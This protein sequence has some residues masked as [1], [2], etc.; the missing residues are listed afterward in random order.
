MIDLGT[1]H[2]PSSLEAVMLSLDEMQWLLESLEDV[3]L[4]VVLD[5]LGRYDNRDDHDAA[6]RAARASLDAR[7]LLESDSASRDLEDRLRVL[8]RPHWVLALR[9]FTGEHIS[10]LCVAQ[11]ADMAV[12]ALRG[13]ESYV[14]SELTGDLVGPVLAGLG[15]APTLAFGGLNAP[16]DQL[17]PIFDDIG[18][19]HRTSARLQVLGAAPADATAVGH[20]MLHCVAHAE[21]VGVV[22]GDGVREQAPGHLA[23]F[24]THHGR[25]LATASE[26]LDGT[27]WTALSPG[28]DARIRQALHA[29]IDALPEDSPFPYRRA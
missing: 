7:G 24:D 14:I 16:T 3:D 21:I 19:P 11:G 6:M 22:Y 29:L 18:D 15:A 10:R 4:P 25:F 28:S 2:A 27:K 17:S 26:A 20:A 1:G 8:G 13:S 23:V 12:L 5:A 9:L